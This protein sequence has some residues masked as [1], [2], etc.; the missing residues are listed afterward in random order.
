MADE[1]VG[2]VA[3]APPLTSPRRP[4]SDVADAGSP[5]AERSFAERVA[6]RRGLIAVL[7]ISSILSV[8]YFHGAW[9]SRDSWNGILGDP[10]QMMWF[11]AWL[12]HALLQLHNPLVSSE[13]LVP[14]RV[15]LM[16]NTSILLPALL[17]APVTLLAGPMTSY[18]LLV[19]LAP[20]LTAGT[21][22]VM[23]RRYVASTVAAIAGGLAFGFCPFLL[24]Q[25]TAHPQLYLLALVPLIVAVFDEIVVRQRWRWWLSGGALG[26]LGAAQLLTG[27]EILTITGLACFGALVALA[28]RHPAKIAAQAPYAA[29]ALLAAG[30]AFVVL[31]GLPLAVQFFGPQ[32]TPDTHHAAVGV[33]VTDL[34][35][36]IQPAGQRFG[37][38]VVPRPLAF[39]GGPSEWVGYLGI[40][41]ILL[42]LVTAI[43]EFRRLVVPVTLFVMVV[44]AVFSLGPRLHVDGR[45][46]IGLPWGVLQHLPVIGNLLPARL[47]V[48]DDL[49]ATVLL[50]VFVDRLIAW[51]WPAIRR[52]IRR[53]RSRD[54]ASNQWGRLLGFA[55]GVTL[56][57]LVALSWVPTANP[58]T[59]VALPRFFTSRERDVLPAG[60]VA[61]V[62]PYVDGPDQETAMEWQAASGFRFRMVDGWV[63]VPGRHLGPAT[64]AMSTLLALQRGRVR[65]TPQLRAQ[66]ATYLHRVHVQEVVVGPGP[67]RVRV[68]TF[69]E[70]FFGRPPD[71]RAGGVTLWWVRPR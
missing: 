52:A 19:V 56:L 23:M 46:S 9:G 50:A 54:R 30:G 24:I 21:A 49:G 33:Y 70:A 67:G 36:F 35:N 62:A 2:R 48:V 53:S 68:Q 3:L 10:E 11:L 55:A 8:A 7:A 41:L 66:L 42:V 4:G 65:L 1:L 69:L 25:T 39:S 12:P 58:V 17:V 61:L 63:I 60:S 51:G 5:P 34:L 26:V 47:S 14:Q 16:W 43:I 59:R 29:R 45:P 20:V 38:D 37:I 71:V 27:E 31:A 57:V 13:V 18:N 44:F 40:P 28:A 6:F 32:R 64:V 15:N 22:S